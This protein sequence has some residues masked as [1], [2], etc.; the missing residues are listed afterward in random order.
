M[1][2]SD[3]AKLSLLALYFYLSPDRI[4][5]IAIKYTATCFLLYAVVYALTSIFSCRPIYASWDLKALASASCINKEGFFLTAS[6]ANVC[7]DIVI[8]VMPLR[9]VIP[10]Q[11]PTRQKLSLLILFATG[12]V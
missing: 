1:L 6:I 3:F 12:G 5:R 4:Y 8:L 2:S 7:M 9:I 10:L 11:V